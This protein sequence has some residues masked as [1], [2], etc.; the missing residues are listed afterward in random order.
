VVGRELAA[1][2]I[3]PICE[4]RAVGTMPGWCQAERQSLLGSEL[5]GRVESQFRQVPFVQH[6]KAA[7]ARPTWPSRFDFGRKVLIAPKQLVV[8]ASLYVC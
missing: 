8:H 5:H 7:I 1:L 4:Q 2:A 6:P 3:R